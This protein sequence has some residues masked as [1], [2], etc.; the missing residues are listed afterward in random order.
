[1]FVNVPVSA[2]NK[3]CNIGTNYRNLYNVISLL[4]YYFCTGKKIYIFTA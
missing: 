3:I 1:M 4:S 2:V